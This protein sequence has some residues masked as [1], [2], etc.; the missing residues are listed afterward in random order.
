MT[1]SPCRVF[2]NRFTLTMS[3]V[4]LNDLPSVSM[5]NSLWSQN[6]TV[7]GL[8]VT[9][10]QPFIPFVCSQQHSP[11]L[12]EQ[13]LLFCDEAFIAHRQIFHGYLSIFLIRLPD[14][15]FVG[16]ELDDIYN[17]VWRS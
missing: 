3:F 6:K 17:F 9:N 8:E 15:S 12:V 13:L 4:S 16:L 5:M 1:V 10:P 7:T 14:G 2:W 11:S